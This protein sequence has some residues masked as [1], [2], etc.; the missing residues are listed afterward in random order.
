[1]MGDIPAAR[2]TIEVY[3]SKAPN[4]VEALERLALLQERYLFD[5]VSAGK[6]YDK[7]LSID[8]ENWN[9]LA[10]KDRIKVRRND[11][12]MT[13]KRSVRHLWRQF[14]EWLDSLINGQ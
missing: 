7:I 14:M 10:G 13:F 8:S 12:A 11:V 5:Y 2:R 3:L 4:S 6:T 1:S 9:A